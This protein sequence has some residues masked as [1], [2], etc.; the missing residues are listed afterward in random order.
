VK[1]ICGLRLVVVVTTLAFAGWVEAQ[2]TANGPYYASPSW[3]Q[4]LPSSTRF[5]VLSNMNGE[6]VLDRETGL[7][8]ERSPDTSS[9]RWLGA[10][11]Q[12]NGLSKA[13]RKGWR[14]PT[15]QELASL[16]DPSV[17]SPGPML[18]AGHPFQNVQ[19]C[20][21]LPDGFSCS[22]YWTA[23]TSAAD[24]TIAVTFAFWDGNAYTDFKSSPMNSAWC[25]RGG[26]GVDPQ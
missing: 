13:N 9:F 25:V 17:A 2:T 6:A 23:T 18:P 15:L 26:Q 24:T 7:V 20:V 4:T 19:S 12:C 1:L 10:Q 14:L 3:D 16:V 21:Q 22:G 11:S 8:W 5:I